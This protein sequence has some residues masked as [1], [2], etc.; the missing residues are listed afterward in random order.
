MGLS[1]SSNVTAG[2]DSGSED[3]EEE[4]ENGQDYFHSTGVSSVTK[5][6]KKSGKDQ[7]IRRSGVGIK[8]K[9]HNHNNNVTSIS[10]AAAVKNND[11]SEDDDEDDNDEDD[12]DE[13]NETNIRN[14]E[15]K[16]NN[17]ATTNS[18]NNNQFNKPLLKLDDMMTHI[19]QYIRHG[20]KILKSV[21]Q[22][23][24]AT[25]LSTTSHTEPD[26]IVCVALLAVLQP[27][28]TKMMV[29][30]VSEDIINPILRPNLFNNSS[31]SNNNSTSNSTSNLTALLHLT[32]SNDINNNT[33]NNNGNSLGRNSL[34]R[35]NS[36]M[37]SLQYP[38]RDRDIHNHMKGHNYDNDN[39]ILSNSTINNI[40][41]SYNSLF[42]ES[43][44]TRYVVG[45]IPNLLFNMQRQLIDSVYKYICEQMHWISLQKGD[46]K[47]GISLIA[48][49]LPSIIYQI[50]FLIGEQKLICI[51]QLIERLIQASF[52]WIHNFS[53]QNDKYCDVI[54]IQNYSFLKEA[55]NLINNN[56]SIL[57]KAFV[58]LAESVLKQAETSYVTWMVEYEFQSIA[59][60][61]KRLQ[62]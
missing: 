61:A 42:I 48:Y 43:S 54:R 7:D 56:N 9:N 20:E 31:N 25:S 41:N 14:S 32:A 1:S 35:E 34:T 40:D 58:D 15:I 4:D 30:L 47:G 12:D 39:N 57:F 44:S 49:R 11:D 13:Y 28:L 62:R 55:F 53:L 23:T 60:L 5:G 46:P 27:Y 50:Y 19:F 51:D 36:L 24:A 3:D 18:N 38:I 22:P 21:L 16:T 59:K 17:N 52:D 8:Q 26:G 29:N 45:Y 10:L 33:N 6:N 2:K 37:R